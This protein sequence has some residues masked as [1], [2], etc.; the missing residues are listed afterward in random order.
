MRGK[1]WTAVGV[2]L[3]EGCVLAGSEDTATERFRFDA[4][5][6]Q[7]V[8][9]RVEDGSLDVVGRGSEEEVSVS[10]T[11]RSR[12][13]TPE[14]AA[15]L[16]ENLVVDAHQEGATVRV[17]VRQRSGWNW[18]EKSIS[19]GPPSLSVDVEIRV[20]RQTDL[21]LATRDGSIVIEN[22]AGRIEA[23]TEDGRLRLRDVE[24]ETRS[25]TSDGSIQGIGM[26]GDVDVSTGDGGIE[27][28]GRFR[29]LRAETSNGSIKIRCDAET[30]S[31][32]KDWYIRSS[33]GSIVLT[34]PSGISAELEAST[35]DGR[36]VNE[37][38]LAEVEEGRRWVRG[39][40]G[41]GGS[42]IYVK[43]SDGRI[44][45]RSR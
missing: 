39:S 27:L 7:K 20:P 40:L 2:L 36:I 30:P 8:V 25:R 15:A 13:A 38:G 41:K 37:L 29:A 28:E 16:L 14:A 19:F 26:V 24:G 18:A 22:V 34:V 4:S 6:T 43:T 17:E 11:K 42:L 1:S 32:E 21:D 9:A 23:E 45:L 12:A 3:L 10:V 44:T 31:P 35:G 33:D 5:D